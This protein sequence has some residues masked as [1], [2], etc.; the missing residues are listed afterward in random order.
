MS[1]I[2][3]KP[4]KKGTFKALASRKGMSMD[5]LARHIKANPDQYSS[6]AMKKAAFYQNFAKEN[7][8]D[9]DRMKTL[10]N[11]VKRAMMNKVNTDFNYMETYP[12]DV[13]SL[14]LQ[15]E[16]L[17]IKT[18][19]I[20]S[21]QGYQPKMLMKKGGYL[22][23]KNTY[24]TKDGRETRRELWANVYLKN[25]KQLGGLVDDPTLQNGGE[26]GSFLQNI[27]P[28]VSVIPGAQPIGAGLAVIGQMANR[29]EVQD[30]NPMTKQFKLGGEFKQYNAPS[31]QDGGQ[32]IDMNGNPTY[33]TPSAEIEKQENSY[34]GYVYSDH[35]KDGDKTFAEKA[36]KINRMTNRD[37]DIDRTSKILQL[38]RLKAKNDLARVNEQLP[39]DLVA[40]MGIMKEGGYLTGPMAPK[41]PMA[42]YV[43]QY[44]DEVDPLDL[45]PYMLPDVSGVMSAASS[46]G[47]SVQNVSPQTSEEPVKTM[48]NMNKLAAGLKGA[49]LLGSAVDALRKPEQEQ[50][51]LPDYS[52]GDQY[53][54]D[55]SM[56]FA[57]QLA[58]INRAA[59]K[60]VQD[61]S[62]QVGSIGQRSSRVAGI[63][64]RAGQSAAST[65]LAQQQAN[66][67]IKLAQ[68]QRADRQ[69]ELTAQERIRQ[70][71]I[72]SRND[73][74][75]R[76]AGR[77]FMQDL[78]RVGTTINQM[79]FAKDQMKNMNDLQRKNTMYGLYMLAMKNPNFKP[80]QELQQAINTGNVDPAVIGE[81]IEFAKEG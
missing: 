6:K 13:F 76:L 34:R 7:G 71:D 19:P 3:I 22:K 41:D 21:N 29:P 12:D 67:Q 35:L 81:M 44:S 42:N 43:D 31:H 25:K 10:E 36:K 78:S 54:Q 23:D 53:I 28:I 40:D 37:S 51:Q 4:S 9:I 72:Q 69:S 55:L 33:S 64:A 1:N 30:L 63:L 56:D 2:K 14:D 66:N 46:L 70:Q 16:Y 47:Q 49:S 39:T 52:R 15:N 18:N 79:E 48:S 5:A 50:L 38:A 24:V 57:P 73:A 61:I 8:G 20:D 59:T 32:L 65:Q 75:A 60:G 26:I 68:A 27:A 17:P 77:K 11:N 80:S 58:E 45:Q 74:T 62:N